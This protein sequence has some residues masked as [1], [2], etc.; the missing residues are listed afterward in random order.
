MLVTGCLVEGQADRLDGLFCLDV[1]E[2]EWRSES[3]RAVF[4]EEPVGEVACGDEVL[5]D[6][7][8]ALKAVEDDGKEG[9]AASDF[10]DGGVG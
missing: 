4:E 6:V 7:E 2:G 3:E 1:G 10:L 9:A 8:D 5:L